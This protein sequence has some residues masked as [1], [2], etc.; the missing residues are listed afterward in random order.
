[1]ANTEE[2]KEN[3]AI[4]HFHTLTEAVAVVDRVFASVGM[5]LVPVETR[6]K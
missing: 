4:S 1:M 5:V 2:F 3:W 6:S